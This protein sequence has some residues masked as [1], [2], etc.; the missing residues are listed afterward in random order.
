MSSD[1]YQDQYGRP[2]K[3]TLMKGKFKKLWRES[4]INKTK[5]QEILEQTIKNR[6]GVQ[7]SNRL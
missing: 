1:K 5:T 6:K 7:S 3:K 4:N 2:N